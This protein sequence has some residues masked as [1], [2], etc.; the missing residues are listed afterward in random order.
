MLE[1]NS[2]VRPDQVADLAEAPQGVPRIKS[3]YSIEMFLK[4]VWA[5]QFDIDF[6][7]RV[8]LNKSRHN[9]IENACNQKSDGASDRKYARIPADIQVRHLGNAQLHLFRM[10]VYPVESKVVESCHRPDAQH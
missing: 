1:S 3:V 9:P 8:I 5:F 2:L 10:L 6:P 7:F 4:E